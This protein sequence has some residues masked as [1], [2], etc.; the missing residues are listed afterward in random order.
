MNGNPDILS[1][2]PDQVSHLRYFREDQVFRYG[3]IGCV[4]EHLKRGFRHGLDFSALN[5]ICYWQEVII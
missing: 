4:A 2:G 5:L 1:H 3:Q